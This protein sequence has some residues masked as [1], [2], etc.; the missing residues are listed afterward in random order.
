MS[1]PARIAFRQ[2][3]ARDLD[4]IGDETVH[5][6]VRLFEHFRQESIEIE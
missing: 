1:E 2:G 6:V 5:L 3:D 4:W